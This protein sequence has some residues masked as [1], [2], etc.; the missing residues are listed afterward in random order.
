M[1]EQTQKMKKLTVWQ[2]QA[3]EVTVVLRASEYVKFERRQE[4]FDEAVTLA[5]AAS[6]EYGHVFRGYEQVVSRKRGL[7]LVKLVPVDGDCGVGERLE[8]RVYRGLVAVLTEIGMMSVV[9]EE[10]DGRIQI[11][12]QKKW[13]EPE[14]KVEYGGSEMDES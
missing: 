4:L 11:E 6:S 12:P 13:R 1:R 7:T 8:S 5:A 10:G 3:P 14:V 9:N 2:M